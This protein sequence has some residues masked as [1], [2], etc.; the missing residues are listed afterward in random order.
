M[1]KDRMP[2]W[3]FRLYHALYRMGLNVT[4]LIAPRLA[5]RRDQPIFVRKRRG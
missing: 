4:Y 3:Q 2:E 1:A 5:W